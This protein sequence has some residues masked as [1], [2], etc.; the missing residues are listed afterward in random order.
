MTQEEIGKILEVNLYNRTF[1][2]NSVHSQLATHLL[3]GPGFAIDLLMKEKGYQND[4]FDKNNPLIF[5][6]GLL[7]GTAYP[8]SGFYSVSAKSPLSDIYGEGMS[9]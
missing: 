4:P 8:C 7:T 9:G 5:M 2:E 6:T 3:G 1:K